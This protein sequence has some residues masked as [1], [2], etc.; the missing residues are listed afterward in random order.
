MW[1]M[2]VMFVPV[3]PARRDDTEEEYED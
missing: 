1:Y 2:T 3:R